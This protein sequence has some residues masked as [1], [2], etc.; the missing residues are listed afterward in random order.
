MHAYFSL[1]NSLNFH[2][3]IIK[4][5]YSVLLL[6]IVLPTYEVEIELPVYVTYNKSDVVAVIKA[7]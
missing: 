5:I 7:M 1:L 2:A 6:F 3:T 4:D